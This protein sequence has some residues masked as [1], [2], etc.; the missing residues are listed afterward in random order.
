MATEGGASREEEYSG[1]GRSSQG[2][3][4]LKSKSLKI[5][6]KRFYVDLKQNRR[7][8]F[9]KIAEVPGARKGMP[10]KNKI[11][12]ALGVAREFRDKLTTFAEYLAQEDSHTKT[13]DLPEDGKL[14]SEK[15]VSGNKRYFLDLKENSRGR[16][17]KISETHIGMYDRDRRNRNQIAIPA[18]GIVD[19]RNAL[20]E[21]LDEYGSDEGGSGTD[22]SDE[23]EPTGDLPESREIRV[24]QKRF[25]FDIG[26]NPRGTFMRISEVTANYRTSITVP[27][28]GWGRMRDVIAEIYEQL[29]DGGDTERDQDEKEEEEGGDQD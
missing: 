14:K 2:D 17:L 11:I 10:Y 24:E 18:Q 5:Q 13:E 29:A 9:I 23:E 28:R 7:G 16:F 12:V 25:Y 4:E 19:I 22:G 21:T 20:S 27:K 26:R 8:K 1:D 6:S 15:V 3:A